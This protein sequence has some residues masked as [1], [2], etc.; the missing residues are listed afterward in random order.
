[1][2]FNNYMLIL[3]SMIIAIVAL[4][5]LYAEDTNSSVDI[6]SSD[7]DIIIENT[8]NVY[9]GNVI[10]I[11]DD[12][13][14]D[15]FDVYSGEIAPE[16]NINNG[17]K[18]HI[19]NVTNKAF[20]INKQVE[21][22]TIHNGDTIK[23]GYI[24]L[25]N[26]SDGSSIHGLN[27][28][29]DKMNYVVEG[30]SS[31]DLNGI[32]LFYTNNNYVYNNS[33]QLA[34]C[35]GVFALPMGSSSNN[36]I[37]KNKFVSTISTCVPMSE[38]DNNIFYDN[39]FQTTVA[40][41]IYY[42]MWGHAGYGGRG[43]C[44][45]NSFI[46][47]YLCSL[48]K[49]S[50]WVIGMALIGGCDVNIVNN[51]I[52][53]V[54]TGISSLGIN[55]TLKGNKIVNITSLALSTGSDNLTIGNNTFSNVG[56][57][58]AIL[59]DNITVENNIIEN[60]S[61]GIW[62]FGENASLIS[63]NI[64]LIDGYYAVNI[65][66]ENALILNNNIG[67]SNFGEG[68]RI[69]KSN[70]SILNNTIKTAVDSGIYVLSSNNVI[71]GNKISSQLYGV[72]VD[73]VS[74]LYYYT[75]SVLGI[76]VYSKINQGKLTY[77]NI[78]S[79]I[80]NSGSYGVY[81]V[82]TVY[83]TTI[84]NNNI[85]T[86]DAIGI[87]E[88]ITDPFSNNIKDNIV[89]GVLLNYSGIVISDDNFNV[90]F[91]EK[92][93]FKFEDIESIVLVITKLSNKDMLINQKMTILNDGLV[94]ILANVTISL[95][96]GSNGTS[97]KALNF[98]N[99]D[100]NA[101]NI[102]A[103]D[104]TLDEINIIST[105][106]TSGIY[107]ISINSS[108]NSK[109][110]NNHIYVV[111]EN[112]LIQGILLNNSNNL[113]LV[114]NSVILE[115]NKIAQGMII[116]SL[117]SSNLVNNT[118]HIQGNGV[119]DGVLINDSNNL[120]ISANNII[121]RSTNVISPLEVS[122]SSNVSLDKNN[123]SAVANLVKS[124][125]FL[126]TTNT[127]VNSS[128]INLI[129]LNKTN[130]TFTA[131][132]IEIAN[133]TIYSNALNLIN[134]NITLKENK[135]VIYDDNTETYF[136]SNGVFS[137]GLI[138]TKDVV[139]FD[140]LKLKHYNLTF[141]QA[142]ILTS[143][144]RTSVIDATLNFNSKSSNS[145]I[146]NLNFELNGNNAFNLYSALNV[147]I[148][149][150]NI[151]LI[152][153]E[154]ISAIVITSES[155]DNLIN[156]NN[157]KISG[158][159]TLT[160]ITIYN[161]Y[162]G[163][164]GLSPKNNVIS[165]NNIVMDSN[166]DLIAI[167]NAMTDNTIIENNNIKLNA[168]NHAYGI[169]NIYSQDFKVFMSTIWTTN[170]K[171]IGNTIE[172]NGA[173]VCL[174]NSIEARNT[175]VDN[176]ILIATA[177]GSYGYIG[178]KTSGDILRYNDFTINGTGNNELLIANIA[179]SGIYLSN[180]SSNALILE[181][182]IVS[183]YSLGNEYAIYVDADST[184]ISIEDNYLISDNWNRYS[185]DAIY[186]P[187]ATLTNNEF[188]HVYVSSGGSDELGNG[189]IDNP[190]KTIKYALNKV[191]NKGIIYVLGGSYLE[192]TINILKTV[193]IKGLGNV[194]VDCISS[195]FNISSLATLKVYNI[196]FVNANSTTASTFYNLGKLYLENVSIANSTA[197]TYGGA[198]V[199]YGELIIRNSTFSSNKAKNGG[200]IVNY[201]K[202]DIKS[203]NFTNN[204]CYIKGSGGAI[205]NLEKST[206]T[207]DD[208]NFVNNK[209]DAEYLLE[210]DTFGVRLGSGGAIYNRGNL[211]IYNSN[212]TSNRAFNYG[213]AIL[214]VSSQKH[215]LEVINS[216]FNKN[217]CFAGGGGA[218]FIGNANLNI[219]NASFTSNEIGENSGG[220]LYISKSEG[221]IYNSTFFKNS[222]S[223]S[224]GAIEFWKSNVTIDSCNITDNN[225][226]HGG[227]ISYYGQ[228]VGNHVVGTLNIYNSTIY[229]NKGF[230]TGG[231]F[232]VRDLNMDVKNSNIY[233]NFGGDGK[234][235]LSVDIFYPIKP[236]NNIDVDGNWWGSDNGPG[237]DV[238][239]NAQYF[240]E[241]V[242]NK[243]SWDVINPINPDSNSD[244]SGSSTRPGQS[245]NNPIV[246]PNTGGS[247]TPNSPGH[248]DFGTGIGTSSGNGFGYGT[249]SGSGSG[250]GSGQGSGSGSGSFTGGS[251]G[252]QGGRSGSGSGFNGTSYSN[253]GTLG[254]LGSSSSSG[255]GGSKAGSSSSESSN[256]AYELSKNVKKELSEY[257]VVYGVIFLIAILLLIIFGYK[258]NSKKE[259]E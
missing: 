229:N 83:N 210:E 139:M 181:N 184:K 66:S 197:L 161:Y 174:I 29:N 219:A 195:L 118:I 253:Q 44:Y 36:K 63:N 58:I 194:I 47:N 136:D 121:A 220:A 43:V 111:G 188:Y 217:T 81:L 206:L 53:N 190:F 250:S 199:N 65:E 259:D 142:V 134:G 131:D 116:N 117:N 59:N 140:N 156:N 129:G 207:I 41:V 244:N 71:D 232:Y 172:G 213:G 224:G 75:R 182:S 92:G 193:T 237:E 171:I 167:Y 180:E 60:S 189:S 235:T 93:Y 255:A 146:K 101:I 204:S 21:I 49:S 243:I 138:T 223:Y 1:M 3:I 42:N 89:N 154:N 152:S 236:V 14:D 123:I 257:N 107:G 88:N 61:I 110:T 56:M 34:D 39:Y 24:K 160:G 200:V 183:N 12:N 168:H 147:T 77:N 258:R 10:N 50:E 54:Y 31:I 38:C 198:I 162:D 86:N 90:Y 78:T 214:S 70:T 225:A 209:V 5:P 67:V 18:I 234:D 7:D 135:Y 256:A 238:W 28:I 218:M 126:N 30:I 97:I 102:D 247:L 173:V 105:S 122:N 100:K 201:N 11:T 115:A 215:T 6:L 19:G 4:T 33:V 48:T 221:K 22:T 72:Y 230:D 91:D 163:Y 185:D 85:T 249:G 155:F 203:S 187:S 164:Y 52:V 99:T 242:K 112:T 120:N 212:F 87:V 179:Q 239:L 205:Y 103:S 153:N 158:N 57:A 69:A 55:S 216:I 94:N 130:T 148:E 241:W 222:G 95:V 8:D 254:N 196:D 227:A 108:N 128:F 151:N 37:Y 144:Y 27:I 226:A 186:A 192:D 150:N 137:N 96:N 20:V 51:T 119:F 191:I 124:L 177:N 231:A 245:N 114:G 149:N 133:C 16:A 240:R 159:S 175:L 125:T 202:L 113:T 64:N 13:Y 26:G 169:Y 74:D 228:R 211:Y 45:N 157:I 23:N 17:D 79:N 246:G 143:Y 166:N 109:L 62:V 32:G 165:N 233:D 35:R 248:N 178:Y 73:S 127:V 40:N 145:T 84:I 98:K 2:K 25:V 15:Y 82:G 176:N 9:T 170:T 252:N 104:I 141:N 251:S 106:K 76:S 46:N 132:N 208:C 80:I 68:I